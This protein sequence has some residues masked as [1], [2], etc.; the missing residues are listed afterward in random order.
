[1]LG[2]PQGRTYVLMAKHRVFTAYQVHGRRSPWA[3]HERDLAWAIHRI[4]CWVHKRPLNEALNMTV[5]E[6]ADV[7]RVRPNAVYAMAGRG[8]LEWAHD[9]LRK[10]V[11]RE[12]VRKYLRLHGREM[13]V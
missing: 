4:L 10:C 7:L 1:M 6:V 5:H 13:S 3:V 11:T 9:E 12:S 2:L 8:Q